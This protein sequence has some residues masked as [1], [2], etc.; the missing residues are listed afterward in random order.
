MIASRPFDQ[1]TWIY[2]FDDPQRPALVAVTLVEDG[3][4]LPPNV[5][6]QFSSRLQVGP[7]NRAFVGGMEAAIEQDGFY[8]QAGGDPLDNPD[9]QKGIVSLIHRCGDF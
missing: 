6:W 1:E 4:N 9:V 3:S 5:G 7:G 2:L 8:L